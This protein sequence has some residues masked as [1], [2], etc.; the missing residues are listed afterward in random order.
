MPKLL[1]I[2]LAIIV[3]S[4]AGSVAFMQK[5]EIGPFAN[6]KPLTP[7]EKTEKLRRYISMEHSQ[8]RYFV[9]APWLPQL[10]LRFNWKR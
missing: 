5:M 9:G 7:E 8:F 6:E 3:L 2:V 1:I 10:S 4:V